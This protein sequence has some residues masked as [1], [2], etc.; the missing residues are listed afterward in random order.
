MSKSATV[1]ARVE[2]KLKQEAEKVFQNLGLSATQAVTLF[3]RQVAMRKGLPFDVVIPNGTTLRTFE[4][5]DSGRNMIVCKDAADMFRHEGDTSVFEFQL[6]QEQ[7]VDGNKVYEPYN[8]S[9]ATVKI[10]ILSGAT[11]KEFPLWEKVDITSSIVDASLAT[12]DYTATGAQIT[13]LVA[14]R[15]AFLF[16]VTKGSVTERL[17]LDGPADR[18]FMI[19]EVTKVET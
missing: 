7:V 10:S 6:V 13:E 8:L 9:G 17:P 16:D 4:D 14:G 11:Q 15:H 1:R 3:Y 18:Y 12:I 5:T 2:P 19:L